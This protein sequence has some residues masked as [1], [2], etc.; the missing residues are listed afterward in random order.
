MFSA[1][2]D[3]CILP[4][5]SR[6]RLTAV[7]DTYSQ[8]GD[9]NFVTDAT[10]R[11]KFVADAITLIEDYGFDGVDI[12][13]EYPDAKTG[14]GFADLNTEVRAALNSLQKKKGDA[15]PYH[16]SVS[17]HNIKRQRNLIQV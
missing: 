17:G 9:F 4:T 6:S 1:L 12:D 8:S 5:V 15:E 11:A 14:K 13:F 7:K 10:K 2:V 3:V 16:L